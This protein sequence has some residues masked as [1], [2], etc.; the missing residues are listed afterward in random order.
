MRPEFNRLF[1]T[2]AFQKIFGRSFQQMRE[3][4]WITPFVLLLAEGSFGSNH[5]LHQS[6]TKPLNNGFHPRWGIHWLDVTGTESK[7]VS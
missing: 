3:T 4:F 5:V 2:I 7:S 1:S 6:N